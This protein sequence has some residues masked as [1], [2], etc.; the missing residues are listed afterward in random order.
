MCVYMCECVCICVSVS[1]L[2]N[3]VCSFCMY[4]TVLPNLSSKIFGD[5]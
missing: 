4:Q 5:I 2:A 3:E 1:V